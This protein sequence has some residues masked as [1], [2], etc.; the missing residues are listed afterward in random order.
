MEISIVHRKKCI[1]SVLCEV[2]TDITNNYKSFWQINC[3]M[4]WKMDMILTKVLC[5]LNS[6]GNFNNKGPQQAHI[7]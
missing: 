5:E 1:I 4:N 6:C 3:C 7:F 2:F